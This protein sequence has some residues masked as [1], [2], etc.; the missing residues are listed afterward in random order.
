MMKSRVL[1]TGAAGF[2]ARHLGNYLQTRGHE[3]WG[4][5][6]PGQLKEPPPGLIMRYVDICAA[7]ELGRIMD[8]CRPASIY[9]LAAQSSVAVS[10]ERPAD[11]MRVNLEGSINLLE[12]AR[13]LRLESRILLVG[14]GEEYGPAQADQLPIREEKIPDP[15]NPYSLSKYFE[16]IMGLQYCRSYG[17][18]IFVVRAF[19]H[20]GPGQGRGFVV[21]DFASQ[22]ASIEAGIQDPVIRVGNLAAQ[23]DFSDVRDVV[24]AYWAVLNRGI[25]GRIY[26]VGSGRAVSIQSI[27]ERLLDLSPRPIQVEIDPQKFRPVDVP[28]I[29]ADISRV[30]Y[31]TGWQPHTPL[32]LTL[33]DTMEYW[34]SEIKKGTWN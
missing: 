30:K 7:E 29:Y 6:L 12:T 4:V 33:S 17:M 11:T 34:R 23:R 1:I 20:T 19:N 28:A 9:H 8:E 21:P 3:V 18:N 13:R 15:Q 10:W 25:P 32:A 5:E 16:I 26:N 14:S 2:A 27:L 31:E 22:I 24:E